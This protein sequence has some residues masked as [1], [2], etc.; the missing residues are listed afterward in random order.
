MESAE[1]SRTENHTLAA[2]SPLSEVV[3]PLATQIDTAGHKEFAAGRNRMAHRKP[4]ELQNQLKT[5]Q[6]I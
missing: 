2:R 6:S 4:E 3:H 5:I 1:S